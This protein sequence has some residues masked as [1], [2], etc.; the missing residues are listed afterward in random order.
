MIVDHPVDHLLVTD[1]L[2]AGLEA[3]DQSFR[4]STRYYQPAFTWGF[5]YQ[6]I[7]RDRVVLYADQLGTGTYDVHY[8]VRSVTPGMYLWPG[9]T[10]SLMY[11][12]EEF[13]RT[14][15]ATIE[16]NE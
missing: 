15:S 2:P 8:L 13:G 16:I 1:P 5:C 12:P 9:A 7:Y 6:T 14:A 3:V 10:A 11:A 4:T